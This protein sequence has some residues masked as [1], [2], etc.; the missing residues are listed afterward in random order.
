MGLLPGAPNLP[1]WS[2]VLPEGFQLMLADFT[3]G[4]PPAVIEWFLHSQDPKA[5]EHRERIRMLAAQHIE[6]ANRRQALR[7]EAM[8]EEAK[9]FDEKSPIQP[10]ASIDPV[11]FQDFVNRYSPGCWHDRK[12][13]EDTKK[14]SPQLFYPR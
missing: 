2:E 11:I 12:F 5:Q 9:Y 14:K 13:L 10:I 1:A 4:L 3:R 8:K 7:H 6:D